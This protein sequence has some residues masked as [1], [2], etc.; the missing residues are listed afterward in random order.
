MDEQR[1]SLRK[2]IFL[3]IVAL[4]VLSVLAHYASDTFSPTLRTEAGGMLAGAA[5]GAAMTID[6]QVYHALHASLMLAE[7][8]ALGALI[9]LTYAIIASSSNH[10]FRAFPPPDRHPIIGPY[11]Y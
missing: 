10:K 9:G 7:L 1:P 11:S 5:E 4:L 6:A 2:T 3:S 8:I